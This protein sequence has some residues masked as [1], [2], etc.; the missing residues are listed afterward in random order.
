MWRRRLESL[1]LS[2]NHREG[3]LA[4]Q[5]LS[6]PETHSAIAF[7]AGWA[8]KKTTQAVTGTSADSALRELASSTALPCGTLV[9]GDRLR[10]RAMFALYGGVVLQL[11]ACGWVDYETEGGR[12][13][14]PGDSRRRGDASG[15]GLCRSE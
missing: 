6:E 14:A 15:A 1:A 11:L 13:G 4:R 5:K 8:T 12:A 2:P 3:S 7:P 9:K 10:G